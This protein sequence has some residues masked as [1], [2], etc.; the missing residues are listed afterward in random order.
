MS[1]FFSQ[2]IP[3]FFLDC[4]IASPFISALRILM[5]MTYWMVSV[6]RL[7]VGVLFRNV[8][9][10]WLAELGELEDEIGQE[11]EDTVPSYLQKVSD[12]TPKSTVSADVDEYGLPKVRLYFT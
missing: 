7:C 9:T 6:H 12:D 3:F 4:F 5:K 8:L 11:E 2:E 10:I 1:T